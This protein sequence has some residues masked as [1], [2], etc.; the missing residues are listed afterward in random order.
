MPGAR[1]RPLGDRRGRRRR[2]RPVSADVRLARLRLRRRLALA[3]GEHD[4]ER[5]LELRS[6]PG[7]ATRDPAAASGPARLGSTVDRSSSTVCGVDRVGR[8]RRS[9]NSPC[10]FAYAST[11]ST[12]DSSRAGQPQVVERHLV[13]RE[14]RDRR[15]VLRATCCRASRDRRSS[16]CS[17]PGPKNS[18]NL[19]TTPCLRSRS[20]I[21]STRSVAVAPSGSGPSA[22]SR[23]PPE[24]AS[25]S[26]GR[27]S[28]PPPRCRRRPSRR[29]RAR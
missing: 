6:S 1:R 14:D 22:G 9:R 5:L 10:A 29:R 15:A 16:G 2:T 23:A 17:R 13:D 18:T 4:L 12:C 25:R 26:A 28:R 11:S 21:V 19:P 8:R 20:V 3:L 7:R 27:A 24:S